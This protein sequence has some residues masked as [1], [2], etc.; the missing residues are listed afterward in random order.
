MIGS[1]RWN[2]IVGAL[3]FIVTFV[4]S[5]TNNIWLTTI[6]RSFYSFAIL[7]VIMFFCRYLLGTFAGFNRLSALDQEE[8][9]E[10]K[11]TAVDAVTP[12]QDEELRELLKTGR[13]SKGAPAA[14]FA[15]LNPPKLRVKD[16]SPEEM[17]QAVRQMSDE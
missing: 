10:G 16:Q 17:A 4:L 15:P 5:I 2:F 13:D 1:I 6:I 14:D 7:F 3:A 11:G 9:T 12:D 8:G